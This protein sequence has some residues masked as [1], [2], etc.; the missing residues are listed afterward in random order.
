MRYY[1]GELW[2]VQNEHTIQIVPQSFVP[3]NGSFV[4]WTSNR[5]EDRTVSLIETEGE[6][7]QFCFIG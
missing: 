4:C 7:K 6:I 1:D 5:N 2:K 3:F